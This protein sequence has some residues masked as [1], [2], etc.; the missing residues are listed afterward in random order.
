MRHFPKS[1]ESHTYSSSLEEIIFG[2]ED[3]IVTALGTVLGVGAATSDSR[4]VIIA[5]I[6][7]L[8][9]EAL[10]MFFGSYLG[11]KSEKEVIE[12][13]ISEEKDEM[14]N[15]RSQ[16]LEEMRQA[17]KKMGFAEKEI[18]ILLARL[19]KNDK[20]IFPPIGRMNRK[21]IHARAQAF[22]QKMERNFFRNCLRGVCD[23][24]IYEWHA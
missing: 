21:N 20:F 7:A 18:K 17:Y 8:F 24:N 22:F 23:P 1:K 6:V 4:I 11:T 5:G 10:S 16:E 3:G 15:M 9:A 2:M 12:K 14:K 13:T 19:G